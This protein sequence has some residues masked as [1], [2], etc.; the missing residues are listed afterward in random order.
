MQH[1]RLDG[2]MCTIYAF[3]EPRLA[4]MASRHWFV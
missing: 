2:L 4:D 3:D 1:L